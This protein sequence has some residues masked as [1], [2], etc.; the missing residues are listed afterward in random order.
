MPRPNI[1]FAVMNGKMHA[2]SLAGIQEAFLAAGHELSGAGVLK[3]ASH[4]VLVHA[5]NGTAIS[6]AAPRRKSR[7][8]K[9]AKTRRAATK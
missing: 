8:E 4:T 6:V 5:R 9:R 1:D 7:A 2:N 3:P